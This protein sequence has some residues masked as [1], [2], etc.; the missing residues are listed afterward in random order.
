LWQENPPAPTQLLIQL[1]D[2]CETNYKILL[3]V[4]MEETEKKH[5]GIAARLLGDENPYSGLV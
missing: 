2:G 5:P 3:Q 4:S 1:R